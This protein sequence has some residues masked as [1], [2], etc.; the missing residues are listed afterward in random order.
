MIQA[1]NIHK[2]YNNL[3]VLKG[4]DIKVEKG[5]VV[6]IVGA[7]G[8]GKTTLLQI[9][10]T[11]DNASKDD[12]FELNIN[13]TNLSVLSDKELAKFR[14]HHIGFIFQF[15]QLLP[16]FTALENVC[17]PAFIKG[18][19]KT[20]AETRAKE[21][22]D[23]LGLSHRYN[24]KPS[25]LSG[26]EQQ[27]VAVARALI[28]KPDLIF[29]DEPSGNLDSESAENLHNLFFKLRDEFG[30]TFVIVTHNEELANMADRKLTMVDGKI[31]NN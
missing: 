31:V 25:E 6:S 10:G 27:R 12:P 29:A 28:N 1:K 8:A 9:L 20:N 7:S 23:F 30:Q 16:E 5:E 26:G 13:N 2:Y 24:H 18:T 14:N 17:L 21:L 11:L 22:L 19:K 3:H 4:V 15:H